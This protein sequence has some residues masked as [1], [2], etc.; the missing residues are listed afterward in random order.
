MGIL[1][2]D[3]L[4]EEKLYSYDIKTIL[5]KFLTFEGK[6]LVFLDTETTGLDPNDFYT[7][8][9]QVALMVVD[10]STWKISEEYSTKVHLNDKLLRLFNDP[11]SKEASDYEK[12]NQR[13]IKKYKKPMA[14]PKD[15]LK[16]SGYDI[17]SPKGKVSEIEA[18]ETV[19]SIISKYNNVIV[20]AHNAGFDLK[21]IQTRRRI[22]GLQPI[23]RIQVLDTL[24][25]ARYFFIPALVSLKGNQEAED[26]LKQLLAK[27]KFVS[28]TTVLGKLAQV[29]KISAD[30]WHDASADIKMLFGVLQK[31]IEFLKQ[32]RD[33]NIS[34]YQG[35]QAK[36]YRK[37]GVK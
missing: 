5:D 37:M 8:M 19:E 25:I 11:K 9:T 30:N 28:Y 17:D 24:Q 27:T 13:H 26:M 29:F 23:K 2:K 7:Q 15:L 14:H 34:Q 31:M 10:G 35:K 32:N 3:I 4:L 16:T 20:I 18:L 1:L 36:R 6:T 21:V 22:N 12:E 33:L